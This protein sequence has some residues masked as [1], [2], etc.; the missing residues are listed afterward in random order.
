MASSPPQPLLSMARARQLARAVGVPATLPSLVAEGITPADSLWFAKQGVAPYVRHH[1]RAQGLLKQLTPKVAAQ[2]ALGYSLSAVHET[3][4]H[5]GTVA[6]AFR[7]L[8]AA[9]IETVVLKGMALAHTVYPA[10]HLRPKSDV[11]LWIQPD[12]LPLALDHLAKSGFQPRDALPLEQLPHWDEGEITMSAG[13]CRVE[14]QFPLLRGLWA[15]S[16]AKIDHT[17]LW[18]RSVPVTIEGQSVR[19]LSTADALIHVAFHQAINHQFTYPCWVRSLLDI[20]LLVERGNPDWVV[21]I[22]T[23]KGCRLQ[24]ITWT[25][26]HLAHT[27]LQTPIPAEVLA[28]LA[29]SAARQRLIARLALAESI[30]EMHPADYRSHRYLVQVA[31][32]DQPLDTAKLLFRALFPDS[33]WLRTRYADQPHR[34]PL[35]LHL[36]HWRRMVTSQR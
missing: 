2:L 20:H 12:D 7:T 25:V 33:A 27:L 35:R 6:G 11:D 3:V 36:H 32:T 30:L 24:T 14:L 15:R 26:L 4:Q 18:Q 1:L 31:L 21:L 8:A 10:P 16:C 9:G 29:P 28:A 22:E 5:E 13:G 23:A 19:V 34:H 17:A